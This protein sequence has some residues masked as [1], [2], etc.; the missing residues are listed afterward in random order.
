LPFIDV[1]LDDLWDATAGL[2]TSRI[3]EGIRS[4]IVNVFQNDDTVTTEDLLALDVIDLSAANLLTEFEANLELTSTST[5]LTLSLDTLADLG[6]D[7]R[8]FLDLTQSEPLQ[9]EAALDLRFGFGLDA[10]TGQ[11]FIEDLRWWPA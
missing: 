1:G 9:L 6:L 5:D 7:L 2:I 11:F 8:S 4:E 10:T 3:G